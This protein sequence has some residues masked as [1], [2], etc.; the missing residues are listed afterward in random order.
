MGKKLIKLSQKSPYKRTLISFFYACWLDPQFNA[1][2]LFPK[3]H[4]ISK[5][6]LKMTDNFSIN[7]TFTTDDIKTE[8]VIGIVL[9]GVQAKIPGNYWGG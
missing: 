3:A 2:C 5:Y 4:G 8:T 6:K 9:C 7:I 1:H